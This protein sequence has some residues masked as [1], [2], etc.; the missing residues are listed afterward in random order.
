M[1]AVEASFKT[2][3]KAIIVVATNGKTA[4]IVSKYRPRSPIIAVCHNQQIA[5]QCRLY[6]AIHPLFYEKSP[7][8]DSVKDVE[9]MCKFAIDYTKKFGIT[10]S[11]DKVVL[12]A[13]ETN[14][15]A[16]LTI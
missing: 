9:L 1:F 6:R 15:L 5:R 13:E 2:L 11:G 4:S 8:K 3:A 7:E 16:I 12:L 14:T 10:K